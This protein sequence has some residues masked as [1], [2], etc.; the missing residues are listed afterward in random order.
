MK[1]DRLWMT[2]GLELF[3]SAG[4]PMPSTPSLAPS[5]IEALSPTDRREHGS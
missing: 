3:R 4:W 2:G 1:G 5:Y